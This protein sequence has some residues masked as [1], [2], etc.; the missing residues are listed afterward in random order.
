M[1]LSVRY[2]DVNTNKVMSKYF[3]SKFF[4]RANADIISNGI[5]EGIGEL[6]FSKCIHL[7]MDGPSTNWS[8]M[9]KVM[10]RR[11]GD[12][13][14]PLE[15]IGSCGLHSVSGSLGIGL[16]SSLWTLKKVHA[17][18]FLRLTSKKRYLHDSNKLFNICSKILP[19]QMG[20]Q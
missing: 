4:L 16:K 9:E 2:W 13:L 3:N 1:D 11:K 18:P 15:N 19:N 14:P 12:N 5:V 10:E 17:R 8:V 7:S 20:C 6:Q